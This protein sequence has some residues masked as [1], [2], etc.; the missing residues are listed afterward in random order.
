MPVDPTD[1]GLTTSGM[2]LG[3]AE[4]IPEPR[5]LDRATSAKA[6]LLDLGAGTGRWLR[7]AARRFGVETPLGIDKNARKVARAQANGLPVFEGD[8]TELDPAA[9]PSVKVVLIDNVLEHLATL[10]DVEAVV[11]RAFAIASDLVCIRHPSFEHKDYLASLGLKQYWTDWPDAHR[12][13][14][15][16]HEFVAMAERH[17]V[18]NLTVR[19]VKRAYDSSDPTILPLGAPSDQGKQIKD[20]T[21]SYGVY[22]EAKHGAKPAVTFDQPVYFAFD[23]IFV[24][25]NKVPVIRYPGDSEDSVAR[26]S[27]RFDVEARSAPPLRQ[28]ISRLRKRAI[29]AARAVRPG[30]RAG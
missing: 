10:R 25:A 21:G 19:P 18:F 12:T 26:P 7:Q 13:H 4:P 24:L 30:P 20:L 28:A 22:D 11:G 23:L 2:S 8:F 14:V 15:L 17:G 29:A 3:R 1:A 5:P 6:E 16:L 9:F 27:V